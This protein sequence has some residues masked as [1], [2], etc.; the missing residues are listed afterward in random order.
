M[1]AEGLVEPP[2]FYTKEHIFDIDFHPR[3][4][5]IAYGN[6]DGEAKM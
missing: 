1:E 3:K 5:F 2:H 6:I 4:D